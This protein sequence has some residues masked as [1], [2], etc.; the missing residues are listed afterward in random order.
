MKAGREARLF[1]NSA[2]D[3]SGTYSAVDVKSVSWSLTHTT[4]DVT[5]RSHAFER[6]LPVLSSLTGTITALY[7]PGDAGFNA[8]YTAAQNKSTVWL[9]IL[10]GP[11]SAGSRGVQGPFIVRQLDKDEPLTDAQT[12]Q[13]QIMVAPEGVDPTFITV[14]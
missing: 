7:R 10:D 5:L 4:A 14:A 13:F 8:L 9:R 1:I 6:G 11:N 3:G 12:V 2:A